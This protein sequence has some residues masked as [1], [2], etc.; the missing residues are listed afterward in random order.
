MASNAPYIPILRAI[1]EELYNSVYS[2]DLTSSAADK[3][4]VV[5]RVPYFFHVQR[6]TDKR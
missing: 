6:M 4:G 1:H 5:D 3:P 2:H